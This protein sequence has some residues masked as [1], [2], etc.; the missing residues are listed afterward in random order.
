M[1]NTADKQLYWGIWTPLPAP[2]GVIRHNLTGPK[3]SLCHWK[4]QGTFFAHWKLTQSL[5]TTILV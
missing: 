2:P 3:Q 1:A 5:F 4:K